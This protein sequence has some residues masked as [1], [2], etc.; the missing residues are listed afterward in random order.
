MRV[1]LNVLHFSMAGASD[2]DDDILSTGTL[3]IIIALFT[4]MITFFVTVTVK[5]IVSTLYHQCKIMK[6]VSKTRVANSQEKENNQLEL[7][8]IKDQPATTLTR[9]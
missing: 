8:V 4:F 6:Q 5:W 1:P 2:D 3:I 9:E 7:H